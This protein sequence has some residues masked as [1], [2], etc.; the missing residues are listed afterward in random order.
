MSTL[1]SSPQV[2][3]VIVSDSIRQGEEEVRDGGDL[4]HVLNKGFAIWVGNGGDRPVT[5]KGLSK[6]LGGSAWIAIS[7][8]FL[9]GY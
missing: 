7:R 2:R 8:P 9:A 6:V 4:R 5:S 3:L 1:P